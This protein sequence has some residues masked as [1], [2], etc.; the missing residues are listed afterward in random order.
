MTWHH[1]P[2]II[3]NRSGKHCS[4]VKGKQPGRRKHHN[5]VHKKKRRK[6]DVQANRKRKGELVSRTLFEY[7]RFKN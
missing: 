6:R 4:T 2:W 1:G 7:K 3:D 5:G